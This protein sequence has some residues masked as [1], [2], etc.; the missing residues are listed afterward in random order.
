[1]VAQRKPEV[2]ITVSAVVNEDRRLLL[3]LLLL[4]KPTGT[5]QVEVVVRPIDAIPVISA[6]GIIYDLQ[7]DD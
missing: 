6:E 3:A 4:P 7:G 5:V 2:P 1:M